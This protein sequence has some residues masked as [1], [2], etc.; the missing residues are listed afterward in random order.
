MMHQ[1][2]Q[3]DFVVDVAEDK[4]NPSEGKGEF[5]VY[6]INKEELEVKV[7]HVDEVWDMAKLV[8]LG[9]ITWALL[10]PY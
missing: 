9:N 5:E 2:H 10:I 8:T 7:Q 4:V 6:Y 3:Y 1:V